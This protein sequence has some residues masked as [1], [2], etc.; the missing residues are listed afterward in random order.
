[1]SGGKI[2]AALRRNRKSSTRC[3]VRM[4]LGLEDDTDFTPRKAMLVSMYKKMKKRVGKKSDEL[5]KTRDKL[6]VALSCES[7]LEMLKSI[8]TTESYAVVKTHI[9]QGQRH[10]KGRRFSLTMKL[11][12][13]S[14]WRSGSK[15]YS[16]LCTLFTL[17]SVDTLQSMLNNFDMV[18]GFNVKYI[19]MLMIQAKTV[20]PQDLYVNVLWDETKVEEFLMHDK[21][22]DYILGYE[23]LNNGERGKN[24]A[25][26]ALVFLMTSIN[27][28]CKGRF[29]QPIAYYLTSTA[30]KGEKLKD[31]VIFWLKVLIIIGFKPVMTTCDQNSTN[32]SAVKL[33]GAT[34]EKPTVSILNR[35]IVCTFDPP[36]IL[37]C[38]RNLLLKNDLQ[39]GESV[40][41]LKYFRAV[42]DEDLKLNPRTCPKL[43]KEH[44]EPSGKTKMKVNKAAQLLS[45]H[46]AN[47]ME[48]LVNSKIIPDEARHTV[49]LTRMVDHMFDSWNGRHDDKGECALLFKFDLH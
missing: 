35:L 11:I 1:M 47:S 15:N 29:K 37:K 24:I 44:L 42:L 33:M 5:K 10:P 16:I 12:A 46:V 8:L 28:S 22:K 40:I 45:G 34:Q 48:G 6:K 9:D 25:T 26:E 30:V 49:K 39:I 36:H 23:E 27:R 7:Q 4:K 38:V 3:P 13:L 2:G 20:D 21:K 32:I 41:K 17:P 43:H 19:A 31:L 14:L 18:P